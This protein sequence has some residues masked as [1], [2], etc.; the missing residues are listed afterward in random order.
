MNDGSFVRTL[1]SPKTKPTGIR[2]MQL[3]WLK[4]L[5]IPRGVHPTRLDFSPPCRCAV[6][7]TSCW[8][9]RNKKIHLKCGVH[10]DAEPLLVMEESDCICSASERSQTFS[11]IVIQ[12]ASFLLMKVKISLPLFS[13]MGSASAEMACI[14]CPVK[15]LFSESPFERRA[16]GKARPDRPFKDSLG[17]GLPHRR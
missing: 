17:A 6:S 15:R 11:F 9:L 16:F 4:F 3:S 10:K 13:L 1:S 14:I 8:R 5:Q 7:L 12:S 2:I